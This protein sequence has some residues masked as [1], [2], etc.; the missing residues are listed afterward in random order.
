MPEIRYMVGRSTGKT[1]RIEV[2]DAALAH[3]RRCER[4]KLLAEAEQT[5]EVDVEKIERRAKSKAISF[6]DAASELHA[7]YDKRLQPLRAELSAG[8]DVAVEL[9]AEEL[10]RRAKAYAEKYGV[11]YGDAALAVVQEH[12]GGS[13]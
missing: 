8:D 7:E 5:F 12:E 1:V 3:I 2:T 13:R 4:E 10:D 6:A 11:R 9:S